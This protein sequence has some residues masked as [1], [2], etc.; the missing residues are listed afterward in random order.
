MLVPIPPQY[1]LR[2]RLCLG[3][4]S[5]LSLSSSPLCRQCVSLVGVG[6]RGSLRLG[7][8]RVSLV[9]VDS[10]QCVSLVSVG[11]GC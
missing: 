2:R 8:E 4:I 7:W 1:Q 6:S 5:P 11:S 9:G 3:A 10:W